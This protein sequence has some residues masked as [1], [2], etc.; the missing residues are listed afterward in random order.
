[1]QFRNNTIRNPRGLHANLK[2]AEP[3][4]LKSLENTWKIPNSLFEWN[5]VWRN[6]QAVY[7]QTVSSEDPCAL[8]AQSM[9]RSVKALQSWE[10]F[11]WRPTF[12]LNLYALMV[13]TSAAMCKNWYNTIWLEILILGSH[14]LSG[15]IERM[16]LTMHCCR[17]IESSSTLSL[18]LSSLLAGKPSA[19]PAET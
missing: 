7:L 2:H 10:S 16:L 4:V 14:V 12:S 8:L 1:M 11:H 5:R 6:P 18:I 3:G 13:W 19:F 15:P 17:P 9:N